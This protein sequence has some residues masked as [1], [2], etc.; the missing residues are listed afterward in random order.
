MAETAGR[1]K[2]QGGGPCVGLRFARSM[3]RV[4][5]FPRCVFACLL[6]LSGSA[7]GARA[8][9][10]PDAAVPAAPASRPGVGEPGW[11]EAT[12][13][14]NPARFEQ[15]MAQAEAMRVQVVV[16]VAGPAPEGGKPGVV[17]R[18]DAWRADAEYFYPA[19]A[20]KLPAA[21]AALAELRAD[22]PTHPGVTRDSPLVWHSTFGPPRA[23]R[24]DKTSPDGRLTLAWEIRK[25]LVVSDNDAFNRLVEFAGHRAANERLWRAGFPS[26]R[27]WHRLNMLRTAEENRKTPLIEYLGP[28][29]AP[30]RALRPERVSD[31]VLGPRDLP[32]LDIGTAYMD[33]AN[34]KTRIAGPMSFRQKNAVSLM[35]LQR[36]LAAV[37]RPPHGDWAEPVELGLT[38]PDRQFL[39]E[40]LGESPDQLNPA[41]WRGSEFD[42]RRFRPA[43]PGV[44]RVRDRQ[45][46]E[47]RGK[48]GRAYGFH[49]ENAWFHD[50]R[51]GRWFFLA[52]TIL[53]NGDGVLN[54]GKYEYEAV[55]TPFLANLGAAFA[56]AVFEPSRA[57]T[58]P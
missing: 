24:T 58:K 38:E 49:V 19:S 46:L 2:G 18:Q 37:V 56:E 26:V 45:D 5:T 9:E 3:P 57:A 28:D 21:I 33:P 10:A 32:G 11:V 48:A 47:V 22:A 42:E 44:L 6:A 23:T 14:A 53:A 43:L 55:S 41:V 51:T 20:I 39:L 31:L 35:D 40:V 34:A 52:A 27:I 54:D 12:L 30:K 36:M 7:G 4:T 25:A 50:R 13:R 1:A 17:L 15:I 29:S 16:G 8:A